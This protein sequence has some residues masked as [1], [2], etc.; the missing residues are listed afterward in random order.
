MFVCVYTTC[1]VRF[2]LLYLMHNQKLSFD[3]CFRANSFCWY[4]IENWCGGCWSSNIHCL[5][6]NLEKLILE[7]RETLR[8]TAKDWGLLKSTL[9]IR[10]INGIQILSIPDKNMVN[11]VVLFCF[12]M[13]RPTFYV[14]KFYFPCI[15]LQNYKTY[16][17]KFCN[18]CLNKQ[19]TFQC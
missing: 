5:R 19:S 7:K 12:K 8:T 13:R 9:I 1:K 10:N 18:R 14:C 11:R 15:R 2:F 6:S 17:Y 16:G 4:D 3:S